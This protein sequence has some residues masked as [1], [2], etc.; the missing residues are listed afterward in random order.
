MRFADKGEPKADF[1]I[2]TVPAGSKPC[3]GAKPDDDQP[4]NLLTAGMWRL[5]RINKEAL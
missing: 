4:G 3:E 2:A 5:H 1:L